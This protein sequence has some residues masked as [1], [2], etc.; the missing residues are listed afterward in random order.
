MADARQHIRKP[1]RLQ[2]SLRTMICCVMAIA[3]FL[4]LLSAFVRST[5]GPYLPDYRIEQQAMT[6]LIIS[7]GYASN[8]FSNVSF[9]SDYFGPPW[10]RKVYGTKYFARVVHVS[11]NGE[12]TEEAARELQE[13]R[14]LRHLNLFGGDVTDAGLNQVKDLPEL[15]T[16]SL[17]GANVTEHAIIELQRARPDLVI[18]R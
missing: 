15:E 17:M 7:Q 18:E 12:F 5:L 11:I 13:F 3:V 6:R 8:G 1:S 2:F 9:G 14:H 16:V 4:G 10:L